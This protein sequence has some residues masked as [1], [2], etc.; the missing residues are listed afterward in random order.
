MFKQIAEITLMNLR[1]LG[2][3]LGSSSVIVV[4]IAGVVGVL[5]GL[6]SMASGFTAALQ[7]T[8]KPDRALIMR[9][10]SSGEMNSSIHSIPTAIW[11]NKKK[12]VDE[13]MVH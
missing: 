6:L 4:G 3:R 5:V 8:S 9:D 7:S 11:E 1:N 12:K 10:G 13:I 2:S